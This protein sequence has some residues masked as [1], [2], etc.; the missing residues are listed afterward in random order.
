[1]TRIIVVVFALVFLSSGLA[2]EPEG[3]KVKVAFLHF[4]GENVQFELDGKT[5]FEMVMDTKD[6]STGFSH[7]EVLTVSQDSVIEWTVDGREYEQKL[8][9]DPNIG[10]IFITLGQPHADLFEGDELLLD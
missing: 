1:M 2:A 9:L 5:V 4:T 3:Q 10:V 7:L 8:E 6:H